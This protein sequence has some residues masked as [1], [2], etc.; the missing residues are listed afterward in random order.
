M[1]TYSELFQ[2]CLLLVAVI[3][4]VIQIGH[5]KYPPLAKDAVIYVTVHRQTVYGFPCCLY[6]RKRRRKSQGAVR[7]RFPSLK[8]VDIK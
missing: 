7:M 2:F 6:Y 8:A 5:K 1:I 3:S 4:L